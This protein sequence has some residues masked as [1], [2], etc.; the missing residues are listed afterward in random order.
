[1][2]GINSGDED[3]NEA[4]RGWLKKM[5]SYEVQQ[6]FAQVIGRSVLREDVMDDPETQK[7]ENVSNSGKGIKVWYEPDGFWT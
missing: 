5:G 1:M 6:K 3:R 7:T 2:Y 4:I